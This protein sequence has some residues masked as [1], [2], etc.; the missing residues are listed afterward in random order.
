MIGLL[1]NRNARPLNVYEWYVCVF[2]DDALIRAN[3]EACQGFIDSLLRRIQ[4]HARGNAVQFS[5]IVS[6]NHW[7]MET[8]RELA[9]VMEIPFTLRNVV[10]H[11]SSVAQVFVEYEDS[12]VLSTFGRN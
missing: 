12:S 9:M 5:C 10:L 7:L 8:V 2:G 6:F 3:Q 11:E 4:V 1:P